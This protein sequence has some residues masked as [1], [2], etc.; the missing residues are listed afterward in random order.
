[1]A[2]KQ[3]TRAR[4]VVMRIARYSALRSAERALIPSVR[5]RGGLPSIRLGQE[6]IG[7]LHKL[8]DH[9]TKGKSAHDAS[10]D[11]GSGVLQA[12]LT[13]ED[14]AGSSELETLTTELVAIDEGLDQIAR[15]LRALAAR[16]PL[17][18]LRATLPGTTCERPSETAALLDLYLEDLT[19]GSE[20]PF[21][22]DYMITLLASSRAPGLR[23]LRADPCTVSPGVEALCAAAEERHNERSRDFA[24][25]FR[26]ASL[27]LLGLEDLEGVILRVREK[28]SRLGACF[29]SREV[30]RSVVNYNIAVSNRLHELIE[31]ERS[32]DFEVEQTLDALRKLDAAD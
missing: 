1:M 27:E 31:Q 30:L 19:L 10:G 29:F 24:E 12:A 9:V 14:R 3:P 21:L 16:T 15:E 5:R 6:L 13:E 23:T 7:E 4:R 8:L 17:G 11:W 2:V 26:A 28:K 32:S 22:V 18:Q 25:S 20:P